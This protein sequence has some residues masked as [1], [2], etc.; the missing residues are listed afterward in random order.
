MHVQGGLAETDTFV[1][2]EGQ[3]GIRDRSMHGDGDQRVVREVCSSDLHFT[4]ANED[5]VSVELSMVGLICRVRR[6]DQGSLDD[7]SINLGRFV[8]I[9][10]QIEACWNVNRFAVH[11]SELASPSIV[12]RPVVGVGEQ[13]S[14]L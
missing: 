12:S 13:Q 6:K 5:V 8:D 7:Q 2:V 3:V 4:A 1:S 11:R 9:H 10:Q 14:L